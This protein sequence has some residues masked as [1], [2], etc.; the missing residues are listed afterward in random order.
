[1]RS[2][3]AVKAGDSILGQCA[4]GVLRAHNALRR[5]LIPRFRPGA[6]PGDEARTIV[7]GKLC[8]LG[9]AVLAV[10]AI[11]ALKKRWPE[12]HLIVLC[13]PRS[14]AAFAELPFVDEII[15]LPVTGLGGLGEFFS[16]GF[17]LRRVALCRRDHRIAGHGYGRAW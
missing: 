5:A 8:C 1:M 3:P 4:F 12:A 15:A 13:T 11:R 6:E 16:N 9:D 7:V 2:N 14:S 10:P 17:G